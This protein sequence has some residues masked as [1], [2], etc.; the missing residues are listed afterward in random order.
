MMATLTPTGTMSPAPTTMAPTTPSPTT[1]R[2][3]L[4]LEAFAQLVYP[5][6]LVPGTPHY[7]TAKLIILDDS[8]HRTDGT[9][10]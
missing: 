2:T 4:Y 8:V 10:N 5:R 9:S 3:G 6:L 1:F 7:K